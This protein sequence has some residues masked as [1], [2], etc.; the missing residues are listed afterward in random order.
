MTFWDHL[1]PAARPPTPTQVGL[2]GDRQT[3]TLEWDDGQTTQVRA[4]SLRQQCPCA[5]CVDEWT[6]Q[7]RFDPATVPGDL[8]FLESAPVGNYALSFVFSDAHRTGIFN[9]SLLKALSV[10]QS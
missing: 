3:L 1:K 4:Q 10:A 2:S 7:R 6:H 8:K 5:E 9:W